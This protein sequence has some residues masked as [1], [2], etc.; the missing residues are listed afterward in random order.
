MKKFNIFFTCFAVLFAVT[1]TYLEIFIKSQSVYWLAGKLVGFFIITFGPLI[2]AIIRKEHSKVYVGFCICGGMLLLGFNGY[3]AVT[4]YKTA[5]CQDKF[6]REFN[7]RRRSLGIP[8]IPRSWIADSRGDWSTT[9]HGKDSVGGHESKIIFFDKCAI[10]REDDEYYLSP[11]D[12]TSRHMEIISQY[13]IGKGQDSIFFRYIIGDK[14]SVITS[15]M[16]DSIFDAE[17]IRKDY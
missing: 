15:N 17:R 10:D 6:G 2:I 7:K 3:N 8:E 13:A 9:W 5:V 12:G 11:V 1:G 4:K 14:D 16:A